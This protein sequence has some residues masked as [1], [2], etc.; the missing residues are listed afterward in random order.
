MQQHALQKRKK[1]KTTLATLSCIPLIGSACLGGPIALLIAH[2]LLSISVDEV[3]F[4]SLVSEQ[5]CWL[6]SDAHVQHMGITTHP[7]AL[8]MCF[9]FTWGGGG[10]G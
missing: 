4:D 10:E 3:F 2:W 1:N 9:F 7:F 8:N 5:K 6:P